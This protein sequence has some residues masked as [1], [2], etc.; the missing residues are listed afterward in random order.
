[1]TYKY[2]YITPKQF[3][4]IIITIDGE[5]LIGLWFE[6]TKFESKD[7]LDSYKYLPIIKEVVMWLDIY[8]SGKKPN[9]MPK[10]KLDYKTPFKKEVIDIIRTIEYGQLLTYKDI[11]KT[12]ADKRN[13]KKMSCQAVGKVLGWNPICIIIP[14]HRVIGSNGD[15]TGYS[16]GINNKRELLKLEG[17]TI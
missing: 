12:I 8:F 15:I 11:A 1:M 13:I 2:R 14:C 7:E 5:Y 3:S 9:F 6:E 4:N 16:G 17:I 10:Y